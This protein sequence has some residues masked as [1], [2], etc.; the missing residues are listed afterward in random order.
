MQQIDYFVICECRLFIYGGKRFLRGIV[1][2]VSTY[3]YYHEERAARAA[4]RP[5]DWKVRTYV[6][7]CRRRQSEDGGAQLS[8]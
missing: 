3:Q 7:R 8:A 5:R 6:V 2:Y 4:A 1:E